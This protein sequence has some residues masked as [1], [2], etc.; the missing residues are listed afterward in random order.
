MDG[1]RRGIEVI[2]A[3]F[4]ALV[5]VIT[6]AAALS[7]MTFSLRLPDAYEFACMAQGVAI[8]WGIAVATHDGRHVTVDLL[9]EKMRPRARAWMDVVATA[10]TAVFLAFVAWMT[11]I[12]GLESVRSGLTTNELRVLVGP[13]WLLA[14][15]GLVAAAFLAAARVVKLMA[16][17]W[18]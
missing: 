5:A 11:V 13:F 17:V 9:Y 8:L 7:R 15:A 14:G 18:K 16:K 6:L 10:I 3:L 12:R 4:F 1:F 2:S